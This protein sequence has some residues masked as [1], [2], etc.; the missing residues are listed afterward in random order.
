LQVLDPLQAQNPVMPGA[1]VKPNQD[2]MGD[3]PVDA[4]RVTT[5]VLIPTQSAQEQPNGLA[6]REHARARLRCLRYMDRDN[7][8]Q[9]AAFPTIPNGSLERDQII[10]RRRRAESPRC[11]VGPLAPLVRPARVA[12]RA[13][14][15]NESLASVLSDIVHG[16]SD[17]ELAE[18]DQGKRERILSRHL[19]GPGLAVVCQHV[20]N[21][22]LIGTTFPEVGD[23]LFGKVGREGF[24]SLCAILFK[25]ACA[26]LALLTGRIEDDP[27]PC[28]ARS[29]GFAQIE[30]RAFAPSPASNMLHLSIILFMLL[31]VVQIRPAT[32][33]ASKLPFLISL[34]RPDTV[35]APSGNATRAAISSGIG[36]S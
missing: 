10:A 25:C 8:R 33:D 9:L 36:V 3:M 23:V 13:S 18:P 19:R 34:R 35:M 15:F 2:E 24:L 11:I 29:F 20:G 30:L 31:I 1:G 7:L 21:Q 22:D 16:L 32:F 5:A 6:S 27:S 28:A 14:P 4:A 26:S 12:E 17:P